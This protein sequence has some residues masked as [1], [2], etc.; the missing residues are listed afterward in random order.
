M[1]NERPQEAVHEWR[2]VRNCSLTPR[3]VMAVFAV[4]CVIHAGIAGV[5]WSLGY[6]LVAAFCTAGL[7]ALAAALLCYARHAGDGDCIKLHDGC[8]TIEQRHGSRLQRTELPAQWTRV[9][10]PPGRDPEVRVSARGVEIPL[11]RQAPPASRLALVRELRTAL[12]QQ[13]VE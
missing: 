11:G 3:Q 7:F 1:Q 10:A 5:F 13:S 4:T 12:R 9:T 8:L 2:L 6:P